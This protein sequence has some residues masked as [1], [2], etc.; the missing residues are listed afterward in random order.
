MEGYLPE[1]QAW[2]AGACLHQQEPL[3]SERRAAEH[4]G[5]HCEVTP[6]EAAPPRPCPCPLRVPGPAS[7]TTYWMTGSM[8][9]MRSATMRDSL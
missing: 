7:H 6:Q 3:F 9:A 1:V 8:A 5:R 4:R 2:G